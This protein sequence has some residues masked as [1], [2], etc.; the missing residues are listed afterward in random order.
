MSGHLPVSIMNIEQQFCSD[1]LKSEIRKLLAVKEAAREFQK[2]Q[3][4]EKRGMAQRAL[5]K[6]LE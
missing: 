5:W 6:A 2:H 3:H 4:D 1:W